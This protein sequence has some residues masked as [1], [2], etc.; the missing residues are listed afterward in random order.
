MLFPPI[1]AAALSGDPHQVGQ[2]I[3]SLLILGFLVL[4]II[5]TASLMRRPGASR[6]CIASLLVLFCGWFVSSLS[7]A[8][9]KLLDLP[10][11]VVAATGVLAV[12]I[13]IASM[14][15]AVAGLVVWGQRKGPYVQGRNQAIWALVLSGIF[16]LAGLGG[17]VVGLTKNF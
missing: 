11:L 2:V 9:V 6:L 3:V 14:V 10:P 4:A 17:L 12:L 16:V 7:T 1:P 8:L 5:K 15:L 13:F